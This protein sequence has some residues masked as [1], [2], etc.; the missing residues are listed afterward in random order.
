MTVYKVQ[1]K[2]YNSSG[3]DSANYA[4]PYFIHTPIYN[5]EIKATGSAW[6]KDETID[7]GFFHFYTNLKKA[8]DKAKSLSGSREYGRKTRVIKCTLLAGSGVYFG[9]NDDIACNTAIFTENVLATFYKGI[10]VEKNNRR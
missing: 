1:Q 8:L 7:A 3:C 9:E 10:H 5:K 6:L 4:S 2:Y